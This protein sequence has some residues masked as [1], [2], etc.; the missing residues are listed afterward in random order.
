MNSAENSKHHLTKKLQQLTADYDLLDDLRFRLDEKILDLEVELER[1]NLELLETQKAL[2][3]SKL[4][5]QETHRVNE[6]HAV[7]A[8]LEFYKEQAQQ[9]QESN[10]LLLAQNKAM[11]AG[12][13]FFQNSPVNT[14]QQIEDPTIKS[15]SEVMLN[16][17]YSKTD[18]TLLPNLDISGIYV[19]YDLEKRL[20]LYVG[21]SKQIT[22][23]LK[24]KS[25]PL[26]IA[27]F[28]DIPILLYVKEI[29]LKDLNF[30]E[31]FIIGCLK[32]IWNF[33]KT[34]CL[35]AA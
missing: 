21:Q 15:F 22:G 32:P 30:E 24:N 4:K 19:I 29:E 2:K 6:D 17:G 27:K 16:R 25:H 11:G 23:R 18:P 3:E 5:I 1:K 12:L 35:K 31:C 33:G 7:R 34:P 20:V 28:L 9:L 14:P 8:T 26:Q 13:P 10:T